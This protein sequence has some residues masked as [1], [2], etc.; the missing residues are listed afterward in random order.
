MLLLSVLSAFVKT[1]TWKVAAVMCNCCCSC[2]T[3]GF[4][5]RPQWYP[6]DGVSTVRYKLVGS[7]LRPLYVWLH[8]SLP[9]HPFYFR[10]TFRARPARAAFQPIR[11]ILTNFVAAFCVV[12]F[13]WRHVVHWSTSLVLC[14]QF[15]WKLGVHMFCAFVRCVW[16]I[17]CFV[18]CLSVLEIICKLRWFYVLWLC[19]TIGIGYFVWLLYRRVIFWCSMI[20]FDN[21]YHASVSFMTTVTL[22]VAE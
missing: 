5:F 1:A 14:I 12:L 19:D 11:P 15:P 20:F 9:P 17:K 3:K 22:S 16:V 2:R 6:R 7:E 21:F 4:K 10:G 13:L 18:C 8:V